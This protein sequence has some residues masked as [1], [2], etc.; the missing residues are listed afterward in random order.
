MALRSPH[1]LIGLLDLPLELFQ[2]IIRD[3]IVIRGIARGL[4]LR[5][6]SRA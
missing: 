4:R 1:S 2:R 6:V 3:A 5:L